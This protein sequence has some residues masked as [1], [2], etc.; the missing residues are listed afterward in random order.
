MK[1]SHD[2]SLEKKFYFYLAKFIRSI[3][4]SWLGNSVPFEVASFL[5]LTNAFWMYCIKNSLHMFSSLEKKKKK[6]KKKNKRYKEA[7]LGY[8]FWYIVV[9]IL[10]FM[11]ELS[12]C[13]KYIFW[14]MHQFCCCQRCMTNRTMALYDEISRSSYMY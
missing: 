14:R 8:S 6:K 7:Y 4:S 9:G 11:N 10:C 3:K 12:I 1:F 2:L 5:S 13:I